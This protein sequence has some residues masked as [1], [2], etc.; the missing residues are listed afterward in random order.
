VVEYDE[1]R[2][3]TWETSMLP[4]LRVSGGHAIEPE[5]SGTRVT[6]SLRASGPAWALFGWALARTFRQN[7]EREA[8][9]LKVYCEETAS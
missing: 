9:G 2:S 8:A 1:G 7:V 6:L 3:F 4:G 5:D